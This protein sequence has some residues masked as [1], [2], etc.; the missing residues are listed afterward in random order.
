M[1]WHELCKTFTVIMCNLHITYFRHKVKAY[2]DAFEARPREPTLPT[3]PDLG[4]FDLDLRG[5]C[6]FSANVVISLYL[7]YI[8]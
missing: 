1:F 8:K 2:L 5:L 3:D 6:E 4:V 7:D